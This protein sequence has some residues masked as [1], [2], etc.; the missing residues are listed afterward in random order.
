MY[1]LHPVEVLT[2]ADFGLLDLEYAPSERDLAILR[3]AAEVAELLC[4]HNLARDIRQALADWAEDE[5]EN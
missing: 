1:G 4:D 2:G 3:E 5:E